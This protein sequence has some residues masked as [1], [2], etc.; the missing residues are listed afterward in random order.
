MTYDLEICKH[1]TSNVSLLKCK[2]LRSYVKRRRS[3]LGSLD[4]DLFSNPYP[5]HNPNPNP[6]VQNLSIHSFTTQSTV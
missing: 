5:K 1:S 2:V 3:Y 4:W 6:S